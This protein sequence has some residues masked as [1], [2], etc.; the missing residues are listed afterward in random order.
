[1]DIGCGYGRFLKLAEDEFETYGIDPSEFVIKE[2]GR[3]AINTKFEVA[4][5]SSYKPRIK[6]DMITAFDVLEHTPNLEESLQNIKSWLVP[7]GL[8]VC[9]VPVYDGI[10]GKI[11]GWLDRDTTHL[12]KLSRWVW[13][14]KF[15]KNL[16]VLET[17][18]ILRY[19]FSKN[20]YFHVMKRWLFRWGQAILVVMQK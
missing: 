16:T 20:V 8:F 7:G 18:G 11:G 4:T 14:E 19:F 2:A 9:V 12:Y 3:Y 5:I 13:L 6:F 1:M 15:K 10:F 17:W